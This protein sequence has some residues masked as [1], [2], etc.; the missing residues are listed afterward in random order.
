MRPDW[1]V[2]FDPAK[3]QQ[4]IDTFDLE[5]DVIADTIDY[6]CRVVKEATGGKAMTGAFYGYVTGAPDKG[7]YSTH[8][9]LHSPYIDFLCAPS[10][11]DFR[12]PGAGVSAYR[13]VARSVQL[14]KKLWWDENDYYTYFTPATSYVE[15][16]T[17]PRDYHTTEV[18][19]LRQLSHQIANASPAW[20]YDWGSFGSP[21]AIAAYRPG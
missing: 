7:Y 2:F 8:K 12:E 17:G 4:V 20:W 9:L 11:Y 6:F 13:T 1:G 5:S 3:S 10:D 19:Q 18:T 14:H 21:E 15:G 16:W